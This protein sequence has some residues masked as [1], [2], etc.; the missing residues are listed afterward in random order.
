MHLSAISGV[1]LLALA[2]FHHPALAAPGQSDANILAKRGFGIPF[3]S[4]N[5]PPLDGGS[6]KDFI[7]LLQNRPFA[8][9]PETE[10][11]VLNNSNNFPTRTCFISW[12]KPK[13]TFFTDLLA[14]AADFCLDPDLGCNTDCRMAFTNPLN[15]NDDVIRL[16]M[17]TGRACSPV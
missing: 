13:K 15:S 2:A 6:C 1:G 4:P 3:C 5:P 17:G 16:C 10:P 9:T 14:S 11:R 8:I 7:Q 12:T